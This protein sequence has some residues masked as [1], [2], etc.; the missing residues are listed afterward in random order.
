MRFSL[1]CLFLFAAFF[2]SANYSEPYD[3][4]LEKLTLTN[5]NES[6]KLAKAMYKSA[7]SIGNTEKK[8]IALFYINE[9]LLILSANNELEPYIDQGIKLAQQTNNLKFYSEFLGHKTFLSELKGDYQSA[10]KSASKA[11][12]IAYETEDQRLIAIQLALRGQIHLSLENFDLALKDVEQAIETFKKN[13]DKTRLSLNYNLLAIIY[14]SMNDFDNAIKYYTESN[15]YDEIKSP[16]NQAIYNYNIGAAYINKEDYKMAQQYYLKSKELSEQTK[17][18]NTLAF[19]RY[20]MAEMYMLQGK[21]KQ[22]EEELMPVFEVFEDSNDALMLYN[23]FLLLAEIKIENKRFDQALETLDKA[24]KLTEI[25]A[26]PSVKLFYLDMKTQY[27]VAQELWQ[28]A[29]KL[30]KESNLLR[31]ELQKEDKE[32][33]V[34]E[35]KVKFNAQFDQEKLAFLQKQNELQLQSIEQEQTRQKYLLGIIGLSFFIIAFTY[36]AYRNQKKIKKNLYTLSIT[37]YLTKVYNRRYIIQQLKKLHQKSKNENL[38]YGLV[39]IDLD[40]FKTIND[41]FGHDIGNEVLIYFANTAKS[42]IQDT[43]QIGRIGGEE[44]LILFPDM[45]MDQIKSKLN[46]LR[47]EY[48]EA[49]SIKIPKECELSFSSGIILCHGQDESHESILKKVDS[50]M[51]QAKQNGREQDVF[52]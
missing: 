47:Q 18:A 6:L 50:A 16:Y 42:V 15:A 32:E 5:P 46:Q 48:K 19:T 3:K 51:Y 24:K 21:T 2:A 37:D 8:L 27:Y 35:L 10:A 12:Q 11:L 17:D 41:S 30:A 14:Y 29:Y 44:W 7:G 26:T 52:V 33:L 23:S 22:A 40:Y 1:M 43:G 38:S 34:S 25:I 4:K 31:I 36:L 28:E 9:S 45:S 39:M 20:G 13:K 49:I